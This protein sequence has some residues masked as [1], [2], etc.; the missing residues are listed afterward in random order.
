MA[1][2][3]GADVQLVAEPERACEPAPEPDFRALAFAVVTATAAQ[4]AAIVARL[5]SPGVAWAAYYAAIQAFPDASVTLRHA[6]R[7]IAHS[8]P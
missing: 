5:A 2:L 4:P 3:T 8:E 1:T 6:D 7:R